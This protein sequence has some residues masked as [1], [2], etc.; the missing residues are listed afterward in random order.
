MK[1]KVAWI[2]DYIR[3]ALQHARINRPGPAKGPKVSDPTTLLK[4]NACDI[5]RVDP[6]YYLVPAPS[7]M[8]EKVFEAEFWKLLPNTDDANASDGGTF[9]PT[10]FTFAPGS[11]VF[12]L[13]WSLI[14]DDVSVTHRLHNFAREW[15]TSVLKNA[16]PSL[17]KRCATEATVLAYEDLRA[18]E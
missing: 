8:N 5:D 6:L 16:A 10:I 17:G 14:E 11:K 15:T 13:Q 7:K 1:K 9:P 4:F 18:A 3:L 2:L 12:G